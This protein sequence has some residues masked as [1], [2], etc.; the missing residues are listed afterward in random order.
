MFLRCFHFFHKLT[1]NVLINMVFTE[2]ISVVGAQMSPGTI[3]DPEG[4]VKAK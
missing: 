2:K 1:L 3:K 4:P